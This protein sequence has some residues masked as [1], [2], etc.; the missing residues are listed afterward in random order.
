MP[1]THTMPAST[2]ALVP[3]PALRPVPLSG[4]GV[5][6]SAWARL[7]TDGDALVLR[8]RGFFGGRS[9]KRYP[10]SGPQG[11]SRALLI[12]PRGEVAQVH[13]EAGELRLLNPAGRPVARLLPNRWLP[14]GRVGIPIEEA[15]RISGALAL[16]D[17]AGVP[18]KRADATDLATPREPGRRETALV[19][20]PGPQLPGW[21]A[22]LRVTAGCLWLL[23]MSVALFS[24]G[25]LPGWVLMAAVTA[26]AAPAARLVLR[27]V[28]AVRNRSAARLGPPPLAEIRP[29]PG[30]PDP[31][32]AFTAPTKRFLTRAVLR[33]FP[34]ELSLVDQYGSDAR[35]PLTGPA[36]PEALV[37]LTG[38]DGRPVGV[39]LRYSSGL[40]EPLGAWADWFAGPGGEDA[41][42][43]LRDVLPLPCEDAEVSGRALANPDLVR[44]PGAVAPTPHA[45]AA[46]RA[47]YFPTSV[48]KGSSTALMAAGSYFSLQF[49]TTVVDDAP[50]VARIAV[51]LGLTGLALQF[52]PWCWHHLT[53]RLHFERPISW[54][55]PAQSALPQKERPHRWTSPNS[56]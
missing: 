4:P 12:V 44:G 10:L 47:A 13:P 22:A 8:Y 51:L 18:V 27:G 54:N 38:P 5:E 23:A 21:Y 37:R 19:L 32:A 7:F 52:V 29:H 2:P 11:I 33:V 34:G 26:F 46:R 20:R 43:R 49:A 16:L 14:S 41:W 3:E 40:S 48:A 42:Q 17:A 56:V 15:A 1:G 36:A 25:S 39:R 9:E 50:G 45:G 31:G 6:L 35:R 55:N 53:S 30:R 28:A 24:G